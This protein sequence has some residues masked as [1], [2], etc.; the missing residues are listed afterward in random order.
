MFV[1]VPKNTAQ[2]AE[3]VVIDEEGNPVYSNTFA[4]SNTHG[5]IKVEL[6]KDAGLTP[7]KEYIWQFAIVCDVS[8]RAADRFVTGMLKPVELTSELQS[9][10]R[11]ATPLKQA[12]LYAEAGIWNETLI[13]LADLRN[14]N[15]TEWEEL[16]DSVGL[17]E[18]SSEPFTSCCSLEN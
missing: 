6:P 7:G 13:T 1:Y 15:P 3:L 10:L 14:S 5:I 11:E 4:I 8:D 12:Q 2:S 9:R 16:L 17:R 18:I